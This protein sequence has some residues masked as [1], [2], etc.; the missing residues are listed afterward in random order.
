MKLHMVGS[1]YR[2][3]DA[4]LRERLAFT[5]EESEQALLRWSDLHP[6]IEAV[7]L[8][9]CNRVEL[10]TA[11]DE[12]NGEL[13]H[14]DSARYLANFH[15]VPVE[16]I[17]GRL[18]TLHGD[19]AVQHL[20]RV[21]AS[22]DSMVVGEPQ[23]LAQVKRA[24]ESAARIGTAGPLLH[25]FFR[26][27]LRTAKRVAD[28]TG[29][30]KHRVSIASV[31]IADFA[32]Q[33]FE[34]FD[35]KQVLVLGAGEMAEETLR[36]LTDAGVRDIV[37]INRD[38]QRAERVAGQWKGA[39]RTWEARW[40]ALVDADL[41]VSTT[42][43]ADPIVTAADFGQHVEVG[44]H[45]RPLFILDLAMPRDFE[46]EVG[47]ALG[48][49]LYSIDDLT[50]ACEQNRE[51]RAAELPLAESIVRDEAETFAAEARHR[52][53]APVIAQLQAGFQE[54]KE[55]ELARLWQKHPELEERVQNDITVSFD[56]LVGKML[57]PPLESLRD[58]SRKGS[59]H[60]LISALRRLF[61][62]EE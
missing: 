55:A 16:E 62:L 57:H 53:S 34:R 33:I 18:L 24:Y 14:H 9:T 19:E 26:S 52:L 37:V 40:E 43:A 61:Q 2:H 3:S 1:H 49:Y 17:E 28:E 38:F 32:S 46:P 25:L 11:S 7:L 15:N 31:A 45:Q 60:G 48:V 44:R 6:S 20:F 41:V 39:A 42:G 23:I 47:Q 36:Y 10:Y 30:H 4:A 58:E 35:D 59:P 29:L 54:I 50:E 8:A 21:A 13:F 22:L 56:R 51:A 5:P 27:A 12:A